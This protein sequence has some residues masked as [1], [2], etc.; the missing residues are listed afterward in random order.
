MLEHRKNGKT[1]FMLMDNLIVYDQKPP[2][3]G[4]SFGH[5]NGNNDENGSG[6]GANGGNVTYP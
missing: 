4:K 5:N 3:N 2:D 1:A 6:F